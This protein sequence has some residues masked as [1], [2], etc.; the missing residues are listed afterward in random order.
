M[1]PVPLKEH[2]V[3]QFF[4]CSYGS[5]ISSIIFPSNSSSSLGFLKNSCVSFIF[6]L[7][8]AL[9]LPFLSRLEN[10][11]CVMLKFMC[12]MRSEIFLSSICCWPLRVSIERFL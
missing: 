8:S 11:E 5:K 9:Y 7:F 6:S 2:K 10:M 3:F 12:E 4:L 1:H